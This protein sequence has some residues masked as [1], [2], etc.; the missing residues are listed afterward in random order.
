MNAK[1]FVKSIQELV[2]QM[3]RDLY[4]ISCRNTV[5]TESGKQLVAQ[6]YGW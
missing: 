4:E 6:A 3:R 5:A 1:Q 2:A